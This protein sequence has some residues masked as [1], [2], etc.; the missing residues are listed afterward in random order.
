[1]FTK[2]R[3]GNERPHMYV[4]T[5]K[6]CRSGYCDTS[7]IP[8]WTPGLGPLLEVPKS[9]L[10]QALLRLV[11]FAITIFKGVIFSGD[12]S[13]NWMKVSKPDFFR[14][15]E[16]SKKFR[17]V[18]VSSAADPK[19]DLQKSRV[20]ARVREREK[21]RKLKN[22]HDDDD[23]EIYFSSSGLSFGKN[24]PR[25]DLVLVPFCKNK[26]RNFS[27]FAILLFFLLFSI[28]NKTGD[29]TFFWKSAISE[30]NF[31]HLSDFLQILCHANF[32]EIKTKRHA[33]V[34]CD[35]AVTLAWV[36]ISVLL[37]ISDSRYLDP[38]RRE[39]RGFEPSKWR[40]LI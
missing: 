31:R 7:S 32:F 18:W 5:K 40:F 33:Q 11:M 38:W 13:S 24:V 16:T 8:P 27:I 21:M 19:L 6:P 14:V 20:S 3:M 30:N 29:W 39:Q 36:W 17:S 10:L 23:D 22:P 26:K 15:T 35:M 12:W 4:G 25:Q 1:M 9:G 28:S 2:Y 34:T 37:D